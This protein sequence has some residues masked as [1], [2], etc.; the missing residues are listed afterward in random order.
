ML[1]LRALRCIVPQLQRVTSRSVQ[2][3][4]ARA[5]EEESGIVS[6]ETRPATR[7]APRLV[8]LAFVAA[9]AASVLTVI[10][11]GLL[12]EAPRT[13]ISAGLPSV[14]MTAGQRRDVNLVFD[15]STEVA[16][17]TLLVELPNGV[18]LLG[19]AGEQRIRWRTRL[20]PGNNIVPLTLIAPAPVAGQ[21]IARLKAGDSEK[22]FRIHVTVDPDEPR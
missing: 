6:S 4:R 2:S 7:R 3:G 19:H 17:A 9:F 22:V 21:I 14:A 10:Y 16:D 18:E 8:A 12:V 13:R 20:A 5:L 15:A 11:T 1:A